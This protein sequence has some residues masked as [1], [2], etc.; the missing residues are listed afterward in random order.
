MRMKNNFVKSEQ[1]SRHKGIS[2]KTAMQTTSQ[3][4]EQILTF[5]CTERQ[6]G[7]RTTPHFPVKSFTSLSISLE[8]TLNLFVTPLNRS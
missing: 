3:I 5:Y 1:V 4:T 2:H 7:E 6:L 8:F